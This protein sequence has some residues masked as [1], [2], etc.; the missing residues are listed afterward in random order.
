M[1]ITGL[2]I[3]ELW[4]YLGN[5]TKRLWLFAG[6]EPNTKFWI[7]FEL[8]SRTKNTALRLV[9]G[10]RSLI[11]F[12]KGITIKITTDKLS[13]Y[14]HAL[15]TGMGDLKYV[16]LQIVKIRF[17]RILIT[18][19]KCFVKGSSDD[20]PSGTQNTSFIERLNLTLRQHISY[21]QRKTLGY[22]KNKSNFNTVTWIN[23]FSYNYCTYHKGLRTRLVDIHINFRSECRH[24][25]PAMKKN[26][27]KA[28][29]NWHYLITAPIPE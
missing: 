2:Q 21:L 10:I 24:F 7:Y 22:C 20:F 11:G 1:T 25:T 14:R 3:D 8:G 13:A 16:Y 29:L 27:T 4:S 15:T 17:K 18:V 28:P 12:N 5:K 26:L 6:I 23:L 19:K 9:V